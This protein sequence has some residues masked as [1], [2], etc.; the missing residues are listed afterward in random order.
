MSCAWTQRYLYAETG[1][2]KRHHCLIGLF[3]VHWAKF[4]QIWNS[5]SFLKHQKEIK[6]SRERPK[7]VFFVWYCQPSNLCFLTYLPQEDVESWAFIIPLGEKQCSE[8]YYFLGHNA[9]LLLATCFL[10]GILL[11][12]FDPEEGGDI[13]LRNIGWLST[14]YMALYP[15]R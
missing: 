4:D 2:M 15:R 11:G 13:S 7:F 8:E 12:F 14:D 6:G 3:P 10:A 9:V 1:S 5:K